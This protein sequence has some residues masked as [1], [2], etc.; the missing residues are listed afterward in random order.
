MDTLRLTAFAF[1]R[2]RLALN[3][4][5]SLLHSREPQSTPHSKSEFGS[6]L[7]KDQHSFHTQSLRHENEVDVPEHVSAAHRA[8]LWQVELVEAALADHSVPA[9]EQNQLHLPRQAN[10]AHHHLLLETR[11]RPWDCFD[12]LN[13]IIRRHDN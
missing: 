13:L 11:E 10:L 3:T 8:L 7:Y 9:R 5:N 6:H 2:L 12:N 4:W 1:R